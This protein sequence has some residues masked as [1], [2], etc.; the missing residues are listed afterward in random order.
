MKKVFALG[1][2][3]LTLAVTSACGSDDEPMELMWFS[4]GDEGEVMQELLDQYEEEEGVEIEL[5]EVAYDDY[6]SRLRTRLRGDEAPALARSTEGHLNNFSEYIIPLGD[7]FSTEDFANVF[8]N[9][10]GDPLGLPMDVTANGMF[11]NLDL[12]DANDVDYPSLG[13]DVW[14][15]DEFETEMDKLRDADDVTAPGIF[16]P[17]AHRAM[18]LLYQHGVTIWDEAFTSTNLTDQ[19]AID[20]FTMLQDF[21]DSGLLDDSVYAGAN[22]ASEFRTGGY[23][24]HMSGNWNV[25]GYQDVDFD[26]TVVPMPQETNRATILGGKH[27]AAFED[28]GMEDEALAFIEWLAEPAQHDYYNEN[29]PFLSARRDADIDFGDIDDEY[30]VF[31]D[32]ISATDEKYTTDWLT[33]VQIEGM[34]PIINQTIENIA[35]G[36]DVTTEL[37]DLEDE[38]IENAPE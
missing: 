37:Q 1:L 31:Q 21:Y 9:A 22:A 20:A 23:G 26:W 33:Q 19:D 8:N 35:K 10:D 12:L 30:Q 18:P 38:L 7:T 27:M 11:V 17:Q 28:S 5:V 3:A 2:L 13:D 32:E 29:V 25:S 14:D 16:D 6:E 4:D 15:W 34:Y 24:F 36:D